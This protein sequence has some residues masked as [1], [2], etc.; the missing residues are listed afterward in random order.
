MWASF[1]RLN[2]SSQKGNCVDLV[3]AMQQL[4]FTPKAMVFDDCLVCSEE[5]FVLIL[6]LYCAPS[7]CRYKFTMR[8]QKL[9]DTSAPQLNVRVHLSLTKLLCGL[10]GIRECEA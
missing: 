1:V 7:C 6:S 3:L 9:L 8:F 10:Q 5:L 2:M 4:Q